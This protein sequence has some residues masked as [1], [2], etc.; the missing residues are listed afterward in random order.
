[1]YISNSDSFYLG[2]VSIRTNREVGTEAPWQLCIVRSSGTSSVDHYVMGV[3]K[4]EEP[5]VPF[6]VS[7][8]G[9]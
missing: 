8:G 9:G 6:C 5:T 1:M 7:D 4:C 3:I 2:L